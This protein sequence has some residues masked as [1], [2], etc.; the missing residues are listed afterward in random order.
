MKFLVQVPDHAMID[1]EKDIK[2]NSVDMR[3]HHLCGR[4]LLILLALTLPI[5]ALA[6]LPKSILFAATDWCPYSCDLS[7]QPG[8]VTE[9]LTRLLAPHDIEIKVDILPW[10]R[11]IHYANTAKVAGLLTA[12]PSEAP[13]LYFTSIPTMS[14][15]VCFFS[16]KESDWQFD[17]ASSL[18]NRIL[19][20][21][22]NYSYGEE[23]DPYIKRNSDKRFIYLLTGDNKITRFA[24][25][26]RNNRLDSFIEDQYVTEWQLKTLGENGAGIKSSG[27][28][29]SHP[30][31]LAI[32][33]S[34]EWS[35]EFIDLLN[36]LLTLES[37]KIVLQG[38]ID[39]YIQQ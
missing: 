33:P 6:E 34:L 16:R 28:L 26:I 25:M 39:N 20:A 2:K 18:K 4:V 14:Y 1:M 29:P 5:K 12:V 21:S 31:Y 27:C 9:Y 13:D 22:L 15:S 7:N 36:R 17:S 38:I 3:I 24:S 19:G 37:S 8:I 10:G 35:Q 23:V 11:A 30:F 32:N